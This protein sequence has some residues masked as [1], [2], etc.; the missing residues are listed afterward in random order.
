MATNGGVR[1]G[2]TPYKVFGGGANSTGRAR[3]LV[4]NGYGTA[5]GAG[6]PVYVSNGLIRIAANTS[7]ADDALTNPGR[8]YGVFEGCKYV[9]VNTG[10]VVESTYLA[11]STSSKGGTQLEGE[12]QIIGY[13]TPARNNTFLAMASASV[14]ALQAGSLF[15]VTVSSPSSITKRSTAKVN[16]AV[17]SAGVDHM[18]RVVGF[19][20]IAGTRPDDATT[21]V[22]IEFALPGNPW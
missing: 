9:D 15:S 20:N 21:V 4:S 19:P 5:L 18:V 3:A 10:Q 17:A 14:S 8:E 11:A 6:D 22:E 12:T 7:A 13:Y 1:L 16:A 2:F